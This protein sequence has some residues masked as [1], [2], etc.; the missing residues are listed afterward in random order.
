MISRKARLLLYGTAISSY[1]YSLLVPCQWEI[2]WE[3]LA[4]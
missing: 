4:E 3:I 1:S 2:N